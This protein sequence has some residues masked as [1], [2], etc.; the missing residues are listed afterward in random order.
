VEHDPAT[1][2][3]TVIVEALADELDLQLTVAELA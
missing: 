2:H 3:R 1:C